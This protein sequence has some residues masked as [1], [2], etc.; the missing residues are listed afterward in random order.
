MVPPALLLLNTLISTYHTRA[1]TR[2]SRSQCMATS[3]RLQAKRP[4]LLESYLVKFS[5]KN[6]YLIEAAA[7]GGA[8]TV[9]IM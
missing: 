8:S 3:L 4:F 9:D 1:A 2:Y 5:S 7:I 6:Y